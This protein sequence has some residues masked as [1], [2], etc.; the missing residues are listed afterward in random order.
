VNVVQLP[1][2]CTP[3]RFA[4]DFGS[5]Y[6]IESREWAL[7][8]GIREGLYLTAPQLK[9]ICGSIGAGLPTSGTGTGSKKNI[10]KIDIAYHLVKHLFPNASKPE[11]EEMVRGIM[12]F[13]KNA[14]VDLDVLAN[15][16]SLDPENAESFKPM[17]EQA[18]KEF[19]SVAFRSGK[20]KAKAE[21]Q[22]TIEE[23]ETQKLL[24][25]SKM[26]QLDAERSKAAASENERQWG[27][28]PPGL[29]LL[30]PGGGEIQN[31]F[32]AQQH[33][34][35]EFYRTV[36]PDAGALAHSLYLIN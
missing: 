32:F 29:R 17:V 35:N 8:A 22:K 18:I 19:T 23:L 1:P 31:V 13:R 21:S 14:T 9:Q 16:A 25:E 36:Y 4:S 5:I 28:T 30:L 11:Q 34:I 2:A 15:V 3:E 12:K 6:K 10:I 26:K 7:P 33:P 27:L 20:S 24:A